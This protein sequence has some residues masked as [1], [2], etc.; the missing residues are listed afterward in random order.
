MNTETSEQVKL[1]EALFAE[2][3]ESYKNTQPGQAY[4]KWFEPEQLEWIKKIFNGTN[5]KNS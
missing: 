5:I 1:I 3:F 2:Y 4:P